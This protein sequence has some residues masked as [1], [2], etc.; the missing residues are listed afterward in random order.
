MKK[1]I[2]A[3]ACLAITG[4]ASAQKPAAGDVSAE[5]EL[6]FQTGTSPISVSTPYLKGRYFLQ[7]DLALRIKLNVGSSSTSQDFTNSDTSSAVTTGTWETSSSSFTIGAGIE[8]HFAGTER[9]SP[10]IGAEIMFTSG[11]SDETG[12]NAGPDFSGNPGFDEGRVYSRDNGSSSTF[13]VGIFGGA[14]YY[15]INNVYLG[16]EVGWAFSSTSNG[17]VKVSDVTTVGGNTTTIQFTSPGGSSSSLGVNT[18]S[19]I[20][21]GFIF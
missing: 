2:L 8:K 1:L 10:Y 18:N 17:D 5:V 12:S 9:L 14:D 11:S 20:R 4:V 3:I 13:G 21:L 6:S 19:G 7:D 16:V 15:F